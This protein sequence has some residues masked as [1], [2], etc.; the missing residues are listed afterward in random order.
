MAQENLDFN[1]KSVSSITTEPLFLSCPKCYT[2]YEVK[3]GIY[4][5]FAQFK[6]FHCQ[7]LGPK[8]EFRTEQKIIKKAEYKEKVELENKAIEIENLNLQ[9]ETMNTPSSDIIRNLVIIFGVL[10]IVTF[11]FLLIR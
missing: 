3:S 1:S 11:A 9:E 4:E 6:C 5:A 2:K 7:H 8:E 10:F